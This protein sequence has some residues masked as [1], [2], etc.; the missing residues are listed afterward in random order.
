MFFCTIRFQV[1]KKQFFRNFMTIIL[2]GA[3]GTLISFVI[4]T[5]GK[6]LN[7]F[8]CLRGLTLVSHV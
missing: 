2:F 4:I 1:K 5:L 3:V 7:H 8:C 6:L